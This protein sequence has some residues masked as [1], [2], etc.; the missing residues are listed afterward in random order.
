MEEKKIVSSVNP[1]VCVEIKRRL[2][3]LKKTR[4]IGIANLV[5]LDLESI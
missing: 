4:R 2:F 3:F 5:L 1:I